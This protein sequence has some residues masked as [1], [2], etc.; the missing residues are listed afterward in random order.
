[1][2]RFAGPAIALAVE[3]QMEYERRGVV[4]RRS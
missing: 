2:E 1:V 4:W 3:R